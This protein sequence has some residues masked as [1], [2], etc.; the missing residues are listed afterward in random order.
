MLKYKDYYSAVVN[1]ENG[2]DIDVLELI[3]CELERQLLEKEPITRMTTNDILT[4]FKKCKFTWKDIVEIDGKYYAEWFPIS[5]I[6]SDPDA[7]EIDDFLQAVAEKHNVEVANIKTYM[8][9][10]IDFNA[11]DFSFGAEECGCYID[12]EPEWFID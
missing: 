12:G 1:T 11:Q 5:G 9:D 3:D 4:E 10:N 7:Y 6:T 2:L 8:M